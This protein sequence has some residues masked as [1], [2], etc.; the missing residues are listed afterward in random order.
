VNPGE[1]W[2]VCTRMRRALAST[3]ILG[4]GLA[5]VVG[6]DE[7]VSVA[8]DAPAASKRVCMQPLG[9]FDKGLLTPTI[10]GLKFVYG[11]DVVVLPKRPLPKAAFYPPRSRY[12]AE[13]L[14]DF[15]DAEVMPGSNCTWV[16]GFT[17]VDISTTKGD[18]QDWGI[19]GLGNIGGTS[20]VLSSFRMRRGVGRRQQKMRSVKVAVHEFGHVL[21]SP[22]Y[23]E[24]GCVMN[25]ALGTVKSVDKEEGVLCD[26]TRALIE[27]R[28]HI[29]LPDARKMDWPAILGE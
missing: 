7:P 5:L 9:K 21:G 20:G 28:H 29:K 14:L 13:K 8:E 27:K 16:L 6:V 19:L 24:P 15:L 10:A 25:D 1:W 18:I 4:L 17:A 12:R 23:N 3:V 22:H 11:F 2:Y 26:A